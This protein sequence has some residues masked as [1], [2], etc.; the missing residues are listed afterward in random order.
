MGSPMMVV[1]LGG[2]GGG[3]V[4]RQRVLVMTFRAIIEADLRFWHLISWV[5]GAVAGVR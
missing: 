4:Y 2:G 5:V 3:T 1:V